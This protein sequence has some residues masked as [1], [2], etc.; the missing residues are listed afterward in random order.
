MAAATVQEGTSK[1]GPTYV[2]EGEEEEEEREKGGG[3]RQD[4]E[5]RRVHPDMGDVGDGV[6][7]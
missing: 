2:L 1:T 6:T 7:V 3:S 5:S 4:G